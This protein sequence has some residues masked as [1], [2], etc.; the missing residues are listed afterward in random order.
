MN[1]FMVF[2]V[3]SVG[4]HGEGF[5]VAYVVIDKE[6]TI[7]DRGLFHCNYELALA[8]SSEDKLWVEQ[9][10]LP[11]LP[12]PDPDLTPR[13]IRFRFFEK[14]LY[15]REQGATLWADCGWPVE[16]RFLA[17]CVSDN[18]PINYWSG[19][20]PLQEI[21][22]VRTMIGR[23]PIEPYELSEEQRHNP[24]AECEY[25]APLLVDWLSV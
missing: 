21:A 16:G 3:E 15:W 22:T 7:R 12:E 19:P 4:L 25:I 2:D 20:Y 6:K 9:N 17:N 18:L 1:L 11:Y 24:L 5:A 8:A 10:V 23:D 14:W 13:D